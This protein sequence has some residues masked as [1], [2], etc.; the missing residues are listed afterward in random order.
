MNNELYVAQQCLAQ[1][2]TFDPFLL[3]AAGATNFCGADK[4]TDISPMDLS[5]VKLSI[6]KAKTFGCR[7]WLRFKVRGSHF[8]GWVNIGLDG[9]D[10]YEIAYTKERRSKG[11]M[12]RKVVR[13]VDGIYFDQLTTELGTYIEG[14]G[15]SPE[16]VDSVL[17]R[18]S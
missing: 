9:M 4:E 1:I 7:G 18:M 13:Y 8:K 14:R 15:T 3:M 12:R 6:K 11:V 2:R 10:E 16:Q 17:A 5:E